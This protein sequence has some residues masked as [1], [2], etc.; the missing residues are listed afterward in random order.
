[1]FP[2][3]IQVLS[4][5]SPGNVIPGHLFTSF[6]QQNTN[7]LKLIELALSMNTMNP[8][9]ALSAMFQSIISI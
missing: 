9:I 3:F 4:H 2:D 8:T 6:I 1:M 7:P 5:L